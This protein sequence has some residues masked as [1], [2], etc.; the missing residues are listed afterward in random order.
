MLILFWLPILFGEF[1]LQL[2]SKVLVINLHPPVSMLWALHNGV[3]FAF[4]AV[5]LI[6]PT[7]VMRT[8]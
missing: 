3:R 1:R 2:L 4:Q 5:R 7:K 8:V 6:I